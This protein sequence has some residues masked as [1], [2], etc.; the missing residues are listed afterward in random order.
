LGKTAF[1]PDLVLISPDDKEKVYLDVLGFWTPKSLQKR[2]EEFAAAN[3]TK[4]ILA[5]SQELRGSREEPLWTSENVVF[6][7]TKIEPIIIME[8]AQNLIN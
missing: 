5:A 2:L 6:Y 3:F 1:V 4:F 8:M 7:K